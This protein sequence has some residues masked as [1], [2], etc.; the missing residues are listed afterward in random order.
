[1]LLPGRN[2]SMRHETTKMNADII[3]TK[4]YYVVH[5]RRSK[6]RLSSENDCLERHRCC[7]DEKATYLVEKEVGRVFNCSQSH[8]N[9]FAIISI[10]QFL[11]CKLSF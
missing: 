5:S 7:H 10:S 4:S 6:I 11:G 1:M 8:L 9:M 3:A 2:F